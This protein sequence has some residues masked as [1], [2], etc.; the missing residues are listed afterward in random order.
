M[1]I[2]CVQLRA[3]PR[4]DDNVEE[5]GRLCAACAREGAEL[6][7]LPEKWAAFGPADELAAAAGPLDDS[8]P[9]RAAA[10]WARELGVALVAGSVPETVPGAGG[11]VANASVAFDRDGRAVAAYRKVHLFDVDVDGRRIRESDAEVAGD[12]PVVA[13]LDGVPVG[14]AVCYD[15]RFPEL[16]RAYADA[17][18]LVVTV[19]SAFL[20]RTGRDHWEVLVRARAIENGFFVVAAAQTGTLA[21]GY[22]SHGHSLVCDPWGTVLADAGDGPGVVVADC[23]LSAVER[24][25]ASLPS[26]AHRRP[27]AYGR[28][29]VPR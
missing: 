17:G 15:L 9:L 4:V 29:A 11:K 5:A 10:S 24:V 19:P 1:R 16:F 22:E 2:G 7:V 3:G 26:L 21:R 6:V 14:L 13:D 12:E 28:L 27:D 8:E 23:D 25:R 20:D 18:A